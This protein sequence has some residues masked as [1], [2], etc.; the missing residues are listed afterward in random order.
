MKSPDKKPDFTLHLA[1]PA[2]HFSWC[3]SMDG[4]VIH[5][6]E[7]FMSFSREVGYPDISLKALDIK[8]DVVEEAAFSQDNDTGSDN[9]LQYKITEYL[10]KNNEMFRKEYAEYHAS[11][12]EKCKSLRI[13][14]IKKCTNCIML[15]KSIT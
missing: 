2:K 14:A 3:I 4:K 7:H 11:V 9:C 15:N 8:S 12:I 10:Y 1:D 5:H 13:T 6:I